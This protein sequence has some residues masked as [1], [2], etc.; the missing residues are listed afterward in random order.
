MDRSRRIYEGIMR[1][2]WYPA[3]WA[4][5]PQPIK[6]AIRFLRFRPQVKHCFANRQKLLLG[7][8]PR[9]PEE[10]VATYPAL[11]PDVTVE[12]HRLF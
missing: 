5:H 4:H 8:R 10:L 7:N 6:D 1:R 12:R 9:A 2:G 3:R 11:K